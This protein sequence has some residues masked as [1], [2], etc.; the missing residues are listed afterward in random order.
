MSFFVHLNRIKTPNTRK[1]RTESLVSKAKGIGSEYIRICL[2]FYSYFIL[3]YLRQSRE[4][5]IRETTTESTLFTK[6]KW[7]IN[8][9][10]SKFLNLENTDLC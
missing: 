8:F 6:T 2:G 9:E 4:I 1:A 3:Y 7:L 5:E 10:N